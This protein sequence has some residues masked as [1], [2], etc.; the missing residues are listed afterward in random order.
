M[1]IGVLRIYFR[2]FASRS[3]KEKRHVVRSLSLIHI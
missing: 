3:L 2:I 1:H